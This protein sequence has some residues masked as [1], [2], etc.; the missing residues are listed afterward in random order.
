VL[1]IQVI[2]FVVYLFS[3]FCCL[4]NWEGFGLV[5]LSVVYQIMKNQLLALGL[6]FYQLESIGLLLLFNESRGIFF[7]LLLDNQ[8]ALV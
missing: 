8:K 1:C 5:L 6:L 4:T 2:F 3:R 7:F